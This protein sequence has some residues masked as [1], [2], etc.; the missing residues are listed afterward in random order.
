MELAEQRLTGSG[1]VLREG[2]L[3]RR[4]DFAA[5]GSQQ[6]RE[7]GQRLLELLRQAD[8][9]PP[10]VAELASALPGTNV[11]AVLRLLVR[12]G[13]VVPVA[14]RYYETGALQREMERLKAALAAQGPSTPAQIRER[15][16]R[17]RKWLIPFLEW[18]DR[19]GL[20]VRDGDKRTLRL[21]M[22]A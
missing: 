20:T 1:A 13:A 4:P 9:E 12:S 11:G 22:G 5:G 10:S 8:A 3:V 19:E 14:D 15:V 18:T 7:S 21:E 16:G 2:A 6:A 17:S